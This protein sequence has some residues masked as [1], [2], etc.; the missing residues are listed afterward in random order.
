MNR[1]ILI[2]PVLIAVVL[3]ALGLA[4][5]FRGEPPAPPIVKEEV[6]TVTIAIDPGHGGRDP[7]G[8]AGDVLEKDVNLEI[9]SK[10]SELVDAYPGLKPYLTRC[11]DHTVVN[12]D[13]LS[14]AEAAGAIIYVSIHA[15]SFDDPGVYGAETL[16]DNTCT[17]G[18]P[19]WTLAESVQKGLVT[20]TGTRDR[21]VRRQSLYLKHTDLPAVSVEVGFIS[22]SDEGKK[23]LDPKYQDKIA[24]GILDGIVSYLR[25]QGTITT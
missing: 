18:D 15:N 22:S 4:G 14:E 6:P 16:V 5:V 20:A 17:N 21:G 24:R 19:S 11:T 13:R 10:L 1:R 25:Q 8:V 12:L 2:L 3:G 7:G 23:L 9:S